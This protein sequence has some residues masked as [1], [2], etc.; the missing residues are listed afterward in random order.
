MEQ[1]SHVSRNADAAGANIAAAGDTDGD[2]YIDLLVGA[3]GHSEAG[4]EAGAAYLI[5]G[6]A[7]LYTP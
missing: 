7:Q 4:S 5:L 3:P 1:A 6:G 2:G